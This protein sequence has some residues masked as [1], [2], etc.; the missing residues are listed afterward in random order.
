M[1]NL[2]ATA[3]VNVV[4]NPLNRRYV[5]EVRD[6]ARGLTL[7]FEPME[8]VSV[9]AKMLTVAADYESGEVLDAVNELVDGMEG[10]TNE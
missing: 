1:A 8:A 10:G 5:V 2:K 9:A 3:K 4:H 6:Y 7:A